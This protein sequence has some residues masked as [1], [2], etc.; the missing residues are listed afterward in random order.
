M[1]SRTQRG[2][3][4]GARGHHYPP[5]HGLAQEAGPGWRSGARTLSSLG[6]D[7][8]LVEKQGCCGAGRG[9]KDSAKDGGQRVKGGTVMDIV[10]SRGHG[11][12]LD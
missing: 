8:L 11:Q 3:R 5:C 9:C 4:P 12:S 10:H 2:R 6:P 7:G 1:E